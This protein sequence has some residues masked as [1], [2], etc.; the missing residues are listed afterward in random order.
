MLRHFAES[1]WAAS[2]PYGVKAAAVANAAAAAAVLSTSI[3]T[4]PYDPL[5]SKPMC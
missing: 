3:Q 2:A 5:C 4:N 1:A